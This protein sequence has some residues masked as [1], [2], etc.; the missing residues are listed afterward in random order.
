M[1]SIIKKIQSK[2][3]FFLI[4]SLCFFSCQKSEEIKAVVYKNGSVIK[5]F[6]GSFYSTKYGGLNYYISDVK[7]RE[8][9]FKI[10]NIDSIVLN[11]DNNNYI[12]KPIIDEPYSR[13]INK[14][15][16]SFSI[17]EKDHKPV[18]DEIDSK[19][20]LS[21]YSAK[22][23]MEEMKDEGKIKFTLIDYKVKK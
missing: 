18:V 4:L 9:L 13:V 2:I 1:L 22:T 16:F 20:T 15:D 21:F 11:I 23:D 7:E 10:Q 3:V 19:E 14:S 5:E 6:N 12:S 8:E 17:K